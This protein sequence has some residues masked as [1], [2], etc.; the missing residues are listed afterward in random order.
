MVKNNKMFCLLHSIFQKLYTIWQPFMVNIC[1]M[2]IS[3]RAFFIFSKFWFSG[4]IES[5]RAKGKRAKISPEWQKIVC[6]CH[7]PYLKNHTSYD[8][9]LW[10]KCVKWWYLRVVFSILK[11]WFSGLSGAWKGKK[12]PK[13]TKISVTPYISG[14]M[15]HVIFIY[16]THVCIIG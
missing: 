10:C 7:T 1:K 4:S 8:C 9:H 11:F 2:I 14:T 16:G 6:L 15:Y 5:K 13:M 12:W 3:S